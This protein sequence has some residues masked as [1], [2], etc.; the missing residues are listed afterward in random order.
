MERNIVM[1]TVPYVDLRKGF[2]LHP[3]EYVDIRKK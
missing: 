1:E 2:V 3:V